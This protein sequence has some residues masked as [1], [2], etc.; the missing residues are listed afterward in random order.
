MPIFEIDAYLYGAKE[1]LISLKL[2]QRLVEREHKSKPS[3][4]LKL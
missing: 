4:A 3:I 1:V 2:E